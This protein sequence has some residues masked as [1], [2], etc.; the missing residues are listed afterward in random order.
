MGYIKCWYD[1][2]SSILKD[3]GF[4]K[5]KTLPY[6]FKNKS[7]DKDII[8]GV[9][10][11]DFILLLKSHE[12]AD[13]FIKNLKQI[14]NIWEVTSNFFLGIEKTEKSGSINFSLN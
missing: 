14:I 7:G 9:C 3:L 10:I 6:V 5:I 13:M 1:N 8:Q 12:V 4:N 11:D 2:Y